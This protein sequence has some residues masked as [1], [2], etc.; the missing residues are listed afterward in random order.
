MGLELWSVL[1]RLPT[2]CE[3]GNHDCQQPG[4][5]EEDRAGGCTADQ[6]QH[7]G[8]QP[9]NLCLPVFPEHRYWAFGAGV[10]TMAKPL[11]QPMPLLTRSSH[12]TMMLS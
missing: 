10:S 5:Q 12:L 6:S 9:G 2:A 3:N 7:C 8:H 1:A 4:H 11:G